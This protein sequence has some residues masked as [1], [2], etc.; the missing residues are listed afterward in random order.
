MT[1]EMIL[2]TA[3]FLSR[4]SKKNTLLKMYRSPFY[5][6][7]K[8]VI[9]KKQ[10]NITSLDMYTLKI[11]IIIVSDNALGQSRWHLKAR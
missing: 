4:T 1:K 5:S 9:N 8:E 6:S 7:R 2:S 10:Y 3:A 11:L